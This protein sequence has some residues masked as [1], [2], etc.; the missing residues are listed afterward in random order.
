MSSFSRKDNAFGSLF[1]Q[2]SHDFMRTFESHDPNML[3]SI[4]FLKH[5][6]FGSVEIVS[7]SLKAEGERLLHEQH[8]GDLSTYPLDEH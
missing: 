5:S 7:S 8:L 1:S 2:K 6:E 3:I 4:F